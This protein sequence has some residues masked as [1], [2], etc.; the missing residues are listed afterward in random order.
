MAID[1]G[2][3]ITPLSGKD[4]T[5]GDSIYVQYAPTDTTPQG[6][7]HDTFQ[8]GDKYMWQKVGDGSWSSAMK[9]VGEDGQ[10]GEPAKFVEI[11]ASS[12]LVFKNGTPSQLPLKCVATGFSPSSYEWYKDG[13]VISGATSQTYN[14]TSAGVY[15]VVCGD[16]SD[17]ATVIAVSDGQD[18]DDGRGISSTE[19]KYASSTSN[20]TAPSSGWQDT[21][22]SVSAGSY[23]WTKTTIK[24][25][26]GSDSVSYSVARQGNNGTNGTSVTISSKSIQYQASSSGTTTPTGT[27]SDTV[28]SVS[29]GQYLWTKTVVNYSDGNST[30][31]YSVGYKGTNGTNGTSP[32]SCSVGN[33]NF[34]VATGTD[35]K[36]LS[37]TTY[38]VKFQ[39]YKGSTQLSPIAPSATIASG[40]FKVSTPTA[41]GFTVA[42]DTAGTLT[43]KTATGTA[44]SANLTV[45][46]TVTYDNGSTETKVITISASKTG[47]TGAKGTD[48]SQIGENLLHDSKLLGSVYGS[49]Y[50]YYKYID[51]GAHTANTFN[52]FTQTYCNNSSASSTKDFLAW[53]NI[54]G[55][56]LGDKYTL[57]FWAKGSGKFYT[58]WY[59]DSGYVQT[60]R[61]ASSDGQ[62]AGSFG[63]GATTFTL[64]SEWK[65]YWVTWQLNTTG[66]NA[67][68]K[69][70]LFRAYAFAQV[71]IAGAK[72]EKGE[73][74]T[75][76]IPHI[77]EQN[78][79]VSST[80]IT[81]QQSSSGTA[82][83]TGTWST[84][85]PTATAGYYTWTRTIVTYSNGNTS[86]SYAVS[87][88]GTNG[89]DSYSC[90]TS[91][92]AVSVS[93][94]TD[95]K[96][97]SAGSVNI[98]FKA[99]KGT[100]ALS[101]VASGSSTVSASQ[102]RVTTPTARQGGLTITQSTN[103]TLNIAWATGTAIDATRSIE[104]TVAI[105]STTNTVTKTITIS[106]S[107]KGGTGGQ[108]SRAIRY[109]GK[110]TTKPDS[111]KHTSATP[112][113][114]VTP[115]VGDWY[116]CTTDG[117]VYYCTIL[118]TSSA[119]YY[120]WEKIISTTDYRLLSCVD[121]LIVLHET[122]T[123]NATLNT[124]VDN[125]TSALATGTLLA[126]KIFSKEI[127]L[128]G[129]LIIYDRNNNHSFEIEND[130]GIVIADNIHSKQF[131]SGS[132]KNGD[133]TED[134]CIV[135]HRNINSQDIEGTNGV[136]NKYQGT[137]IWVDGYTIQATTDSGS[138]S[139]QKRQKSILR[140][141]KYG[142]SIIIGDYDNSYP[143][144]NVINS[145]LPLFIPA[146]GNPTYSP[147]AYR[148]GSAKS[149][150]IIQCSLD[151]S[152]KTYKG[153]WASNKSYAVG[154]VVQY[155]PDN[156]PTDYYECNTAHTSS[157]SIDMSKWTSATQS[158]YIVFSN[159]LKIQ[160]GVKTDSSTWHDTSINFSINFSTTNYLFV[161]D[162]EYWADGLYDS[163]ITKQISNITFYCI[164]KHHGFKNWLAIGY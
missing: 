107:I 69:H 135:S 75:A 60:K 122:L 64:T 126:N 137:G 86:T 45:S 72:F 132:V 27:W 116:L 59:G 149:L 95:R 8:S 52:G 10:D 157:S 6:Q 131:I 104:V 70:I 121:D 21:P 34:T 162:Y 164:A 83:P 100:T 48:A 71:Y 79:T 3:T 77:D 5:S 109:I 130:G 146:L 19:I 113:S 139:T 101:A 136:Y 114:G 43:F 111:N 117:Y 153:Q 15:K 142:G 18:G 44:I 87:K 163:K 74:A 73:T 110:S 50:P 84:T 88:N 4:G 82:V 53:T 36:P 37:A 32:Y 78:I 128:S 151:L 85:P 129:D 1:E 124:I 80:A 62:T 65:Q 144:S 42:Q 40:K 93:T 39:A 14:A 26:S 17:I 105:G 41:S 138:T 120:T 25:T 123:A 158:G 66:N 133:S 140:I 92:S 143:E 46:V 2:Y 51:N 31:S 24:Y 145:Y 61:I 35:L 38:S 99:F 47:N 67:V 152:E 9:I 13:T 81:Y 159:G 148:L 11:E 103:G 28:P 7:R 63:D 57:S 115:I 134:G 155:T 150:G 68:S 156:S 141:Q 90:E 161:G 108:G 20:T 12:G 118:P 56:T 127:N 154:D 49:S 160:W 55:F 16:Y 147:N 97:T 23:L 30:T 102:F 91:A 119:N 33:E 112:I 76:W 125:Y 94:G 58:Y 89:V 96:P 98:V 106:A 54:K 29:T 22:P